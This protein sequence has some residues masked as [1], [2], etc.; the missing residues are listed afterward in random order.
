MPTF[1]INPFMRRQTP[2][3]R[4][5]HFDGADAD[6]LARVITGFDH[7]RPGYRDG[8]LLVPISPEDCWSTTVKL[9]EGDQLQGR[10]EARAAGE[11]PRKNTYVVGRSKQPAVAVDVVLYRSDVLREN[12]EQSSEADW[13]M[14]ALLA[15][16]SES[17]EPMSP[18]TL[19]ANHFE[20]SG[21]TAT[22]LSDADFVAKLRES[23]LYWRD[24]ALCQP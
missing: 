24:R 19:M 13:E 14:V 5:S 10:F 16:S 23:F 21:G 4:F 17:P 18:G 7:A 1:A 9:V 15:R 11:E 12:D 6:L 2:E 20:I 8:V 22:H 3:S